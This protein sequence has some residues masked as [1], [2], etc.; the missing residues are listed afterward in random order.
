MWFRQGEEHYADLEI[1][2]DL[3]VPEGDRLAGR[4]WQIGGAYGE[5][6]LSLTSRSAGMPDFALIFGPSY[7]MTLRITNKTRTAVEGTIDLKITEPANTFLRGPFTAEYR[8]SA[9]A[10][11]D[12]SDAPFVQGK[13]AIKGSDRKW[14]LSVGFAGMGD[15]GQPHLNSAGFP[16]MIGQT[17][18]VTNGMFAPQVTS[19][20][21]D[22]AAGLVHRHIKLPPGDYPVYARR[23]EVL[24]TW[25]R[26]RIK[27]GDQITLDLLFDLT[28][29]GDIA[30]TLPDSEARE[31]AMI[32][33]GVDLPELGS[34]KLATFTAA[35][36]K[37]AKRP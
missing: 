24:Y 8:K 5:P 4:E 36:V 10:P 34:K 16:L 32:P 31:L 26:V 12:E 3:P 14:D 25:E 13:I 7:T 15:D 9:T 11:L 19:L 6:N 22:T 37:A 27:D 29:A 1:R 35:H 30:F 2:F 23:N 20:V 28:T 18:S 17:G 21:N 33:I